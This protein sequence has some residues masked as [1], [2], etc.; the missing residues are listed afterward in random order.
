MDVGL[1]IAAQGMLTEQVRQ[2]QLSNDLANA[3]TPGYKSDHTT[4]QD[5]G[6]LLLSSTATG[7][8]LGSIETGLRV[9]QVVTD[10]TPAGVH[11][12]GQALDFAIEGSGFF[13]VQTAQGTR[14]TRDGQ[15]HASAQGV[16]VDAQ[17]D[18]VL[19]QSGTPLAVTRGGTVAPGSL[20]V[21]TVAGAAKQGDNVYAGTASG[22]GTGTVAQGVLEDSSVDAVHTMVDMIAS[23][24]A[25]ESGQKAISAIDETLQ[26]SAQ[27]VGSLGG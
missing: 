21:F 27:S 13:A 11:E 8:Q 12:T 24:R 17:G 25:Y 1:Y 7:Q 20:G 9:G 15:F 22:R 6:A 14:F 16:L 10:L 4:Q 3:S 5:F 23:L 2:D 18:P 19:A 26:Q